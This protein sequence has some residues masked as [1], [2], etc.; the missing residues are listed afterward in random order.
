MPE[1][2]FPKSTQ[3]TH[4][5]SLY[6]GGSLKNLKSDWANLIFY[7]QFLVKVDKMNELRFKIWIRWDPAALQGFYFQALVSETWMLNAFLFKL[8]FQNYYRSFLHKPPRVLM[9]GCFVTRSS[10][11]L[12]LFC[13]IVC[14]S[15]S[16]VSGHHC[17]P[18][19]FWRR[20]RTA[21]TETEADPQPE[22]RTFWAGIVAG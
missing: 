1:G 16:D 3:N 15:W 11:C 2:T 22:S 7:C 18:G 20:R 4:Q 9:W 8:H 5:K 14:R 19:V 17:G 12:C 6:Q 13:E 21:E 10:V